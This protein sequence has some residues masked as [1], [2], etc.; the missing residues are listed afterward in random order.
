MKWIKSEE[1][2]PKL[3]K[4]K[5]VSDGIN[6]H[7]GYR[8]ADYLTPEKWGWKFLGNAPR[9]KVKYWMDLP[10]PPEDQKARK[11]INNLEPNKP[12]GTYTG[13]EDYHNFA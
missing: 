12:D 8:D 11:I 9:F 1:S 5:I 2:L 4:Y 13:D 6:I 7:L 3:M 10:E